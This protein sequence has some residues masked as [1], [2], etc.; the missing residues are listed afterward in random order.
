MT[1]Q[2]TRT[3][4]VALSAAIAMSIACGSRTDSP[5]ASEVTARWSQAINSGD[6]AT[7]TN[8]YAEDA[9]LLPPEGSALEG[10]RVIESYWRDDIGDARATTT[11]TPEATLTLDDALHVQGSYVVAAPDGTT[12]AAGQYEQLWTRAGAD[13]RVQREMW[14]LSPAAGSG[15]EV[16]D[17]LTARWTAAYNATD[18]KALTALYSDDAVLS[19]PRGGSLPGRAAI[20]AFWAAD[21]DDGAPSTTLTLRDAYVAGTM[22]HLE[23]EFLVVDKGIETVG[24]YVQ[25]WVRDAGDWRIHRELWW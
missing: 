6:V 20:E 15:H 17:R 25:L 21:F 19:T 22:A 2:T 3:A 13:W 14:Q 24:R 12:L 11:L 5:E 9:R 10:R 18:P 16:A 23:G 7:L 1:R 4:L 8:L